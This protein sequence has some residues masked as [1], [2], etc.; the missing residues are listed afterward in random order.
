[1][2]EAIKVSW[3]LVLSAGFLVA[4]FSWVND[5]PDSLTWA[6]RF[7]GPAAALLGFG[8]FLKMHYRADLV[9]DYLRDVA[10]WYFNRGGFCF[11]FAVQAVDGVAYLAMYFQNQRDRPCV[12]RV[13]LRQAE[14]FFLR[15]APIE[16]ITFK[17][18][19]EPAAFGIAR[20]E[21]PIPIKMQGKRESFDVGA[22][23]QFPGGKGRQLRFRDGIV[24]RTNANFNDS[25]GTALA[26]AGMLGGHIA[27]HSSPSIKIALPSGVAEDLGGEPIIE[28]RTLWRLAEPP[29]QKI[30]REGV[31]VEWSDAPS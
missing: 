26:I 18:E 27:I 14:G 29:L 24:I 3:V 9:H 23:V 13:A 10:P 15:G 21:L 25:F 19:C 2:R 31:F 8:A 11:A 5:R 20:I 6:C 12:G 4:C 30:G 17:I 22:L 28:V 16:A 7:G 1:M